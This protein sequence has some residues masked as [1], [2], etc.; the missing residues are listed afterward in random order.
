MHRRIRPV[1][2]SYS[3]RGA[4]ELDSFHTPKDLCL[5]EPIYWILDSSHLAAINQSNLAAG[6]EV[7]L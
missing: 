6:R 1:P 4:S 5:S 2:L 3:E 7:I